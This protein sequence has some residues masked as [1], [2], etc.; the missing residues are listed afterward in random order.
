MIIH[1]CK[2]IH[3]ILSTRPLPGGNNA[4]VLWSLPGGNNTVVQVCYKISLA[5]DGLVRV[6]YV[7]PSTVSY[8]WYH[9]RSCTGGLCFTIDGLVR[10][11]PP[12]V[13]YGWVMIKHE[14]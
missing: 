12:T 11:V 8:G 6:G 14:L 10:M 4:V 9:R 2:S 7:L 3:G 5:T 13:L 1:I